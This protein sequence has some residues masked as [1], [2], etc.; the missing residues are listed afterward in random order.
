MPPAASPPSLY[1]ALPNSHTSSNP[2]SH[3]ESSSF[4]PASSTH[5]LSESPSQNPTPK[6][7]FDQ[8]GEEGEEGHKKKFK[9]IGARWREIGYLAAVSQLIGAYIFYI[10]CVTGT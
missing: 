1:P 5:E 10:A 7:Q 2:P 9:F 6:K 8:E 3:Q 4:D